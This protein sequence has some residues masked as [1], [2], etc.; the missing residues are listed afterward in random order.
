M[1]EE[2]KPTEWQKIE[3]RRKFLK[4]AGVFA[5]AAAIAGCAPTHP[6]PRKP[7]SRQSKC[8]SKWKRK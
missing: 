8:R 2:T 6:P 4:G 5:A 1:S 3:S 7:S